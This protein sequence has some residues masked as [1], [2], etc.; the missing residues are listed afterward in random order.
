MTTKEIQVL[1]NPDAKRL[2]VVSQCL[3]HEFEIEETKYGKVEKINVP[4]PDCDKALDGVCISYLDP[5]KIWRLGCGLASNKIQVTE[6]GKPINPI[7]ASKRGIQTSF[8][9]KRKNR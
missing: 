9:R 3:A 6:K 8:E 7:K 4:M 1:P 5:A 2:P